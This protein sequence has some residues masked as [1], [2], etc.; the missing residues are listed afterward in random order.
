M[1]INMELNSILAVASS[2]VTGYLLGSIMFAIVISTL[3]Y[4][5]D[6]RTLGSGNA[7]MSNMMRNFGKKAGI[8]T[9]VGDVLKGMTSVMLASFLAENLFMVDE[10]ILLICGYLAAF[11]AVFGHMKPLYYNFK[12]GK[13]VATGLGCMLGLFV[14]L[15]PVLLIVFFIAFKTSRMFSVGSIAASLFAPVA[16]LVLKVTGLV[17]FHWLDI[18]LTAI[19]AGIIVFMHHENIKRILNGTETRYVKK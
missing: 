19:L 9:F 7:G 13:G 3:K 10:F 4:K 12:G 5:Q 16:L 11:A 17:E 15:A 18:V 8:V 2:L 1:D 6:I 14:P